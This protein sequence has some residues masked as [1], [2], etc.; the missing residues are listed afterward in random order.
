[1]GR[2]AWRAMQGA[3]GSWGRVVLRGEAV[4]SEF[5]LYNFMGYL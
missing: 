1:V 4:G 2:E 5:I 3:S